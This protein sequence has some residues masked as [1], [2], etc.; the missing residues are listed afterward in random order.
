MHNPLEPVAHL[1]FRVADVDIIGRCAI[2]WL[3]DD[4]PAPVRCGP[5]ARLVFRRHQ[6][7]PGGVKTGGA[8]PFDHLEFIAANARCRWIVPAHAKPSPQRIRQF[9]GGFIPRQ[10]AANIITRKLR[11]QRVKVAG[12]G[13]HRLKITGAI[14]TQ[15]RFD[16]GGS[17]LNRD[18]AIA[19]AAQV[20]RKENTRRI[21]ID[22]QRAGGGHAVCSSWAA[23]RRPYHRVQIY[24]IVCKK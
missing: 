16:E 21:G 8:N 7:L 14:G 5:I 15:E 2:E 23:L 18:A 24:T 3:D 17:A 6:L 10:H 9:N 11:H 22:N 1:G 19:P 13:D 20:T 12:M 4:R